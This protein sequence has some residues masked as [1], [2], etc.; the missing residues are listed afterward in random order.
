MVCNL[1]FDLG[2]QSSRETATFTMWVAAT[3][4]GLDSLE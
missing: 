3:E 1:T 2:K 4:H